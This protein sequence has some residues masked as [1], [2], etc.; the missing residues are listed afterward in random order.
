MWTL[1]PS[2]NGIYK[3]LVA[4][5]KK[6]KSTCVPFQYPAD[7]QLGK[8]VRTQRKLYNTNQPSLT[9]ERITQLNSIGFVWNLFDAQWME[10]YERLVKYKKEYKTT[11]VSW[12]YPA[13]PHLGA[14]VRT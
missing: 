2:W 11:C 13:D 4:Y 12:R 1:K 7:Q 5:R 6:Y 10:M 8:W 9:A 3:Q 14:W